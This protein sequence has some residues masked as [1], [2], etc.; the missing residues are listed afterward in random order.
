LQQAIRDLLP[1]AL[2]DPHGKIRTAVGMAIASIASWDWPEE[3]PGLMG[4]LLGLI[5]D[6]SDAN[7]VHGAL[8]CLALFAG[9]L[10]DIQ[11]PP[12]IPV[13]FPA[14]YSIVS[15]SEVWSFSDT[16]LQSCDFSGLAKLILDCFL[17]E[18]CILMLLYSFLGYF[19]GLDVL[20]ECLQL[21]QLSS[22]RDGD[23][24]MIQH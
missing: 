21:M 14:L 11:L 24:I 23:R 10:D 9:D 2:E 18:L 8:R 7:K 17:S 19:L 20:G 16:F 5:S 22:L 13:L 6:R 1:Q 15:A 3:W 12:L 4:Y